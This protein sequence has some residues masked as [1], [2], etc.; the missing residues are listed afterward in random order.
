ME[1]GIVIYR[2][3]YG[4]AKKYAHWIAQKTGF[5]CMEAAN[6]CFGTTK[7]GMET[8]TAYNTVIF[9]GGI[10]A[11]GISG[12]SLLR[13]HY[14]KLRGKRLAIFCVGASPYSQKALGEIRTHNLKGELADIPLFYG[15]GAW[16]EKAMSFKDRTLCRILK[17]AV[18]KTPLDA[19]EPWMRA[20][21]CASGQECDWTDEKYLDGLME[22]LHIHRL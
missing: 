9:C 13:K 19:Q 14:P 17:K 18:A 21:L 11:S 12:L 22:F 3:K 15:R 1:N 10:Y 20:L 6:C 4:S 16:N 7:P 5:F 8:P 2:S